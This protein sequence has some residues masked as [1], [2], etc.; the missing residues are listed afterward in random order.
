[1]R[2]N[3]VDRIV[4]AEPGRSLKAM[5]LLTAGEEYLA[6]HFPAFPVMPGVLQLQALV[7]SASWLWR[8]TDD[9]AHSVIALREVRSV[10][11]GSFVQPGHA[12]TLT[13]ELTG[14]DGAAATFKGKG[15]VN[16]QTTVSAQFALTAYN[17]ADRD[18]AKREIDERL[19]RHWKE[20]C[21]WLRPVR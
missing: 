17:L 18:P 13:V 20:R 9:F 14:R 10:K 15:E 6:D 12:L 3:L 19:V 2:F 21:A 5:K 7:E 11:Y 8:L 4:S 1:M 16:G